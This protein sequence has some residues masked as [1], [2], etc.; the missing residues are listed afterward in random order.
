MT[1]IVLE[2][3]FAEVSTKIRQTKAQKETASS[4]FILKTLPMEDLKNLTVVGL[5]I[6]HDFLKL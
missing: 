1:T 5:L 3:L 6:C 2:T 4:N